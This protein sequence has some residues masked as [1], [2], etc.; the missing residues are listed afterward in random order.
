MPD[1]ADVSRLIDQTVRTLP[2][3]FY[4]G[5]TRQSDSQIVTVDIGDDRAAMDI[6]MYGVT[7][8]AVTGR[9]VPSGGPPTQ[10]VQIVLVQ[11]GDMPGAIGVSEIQPVQ[12]SADGRFRFAGVAPGTYSLLVLPTTQQR[13]G[14]NGYLPVTV[15][16][17]DVED[18]VVTLG[19]GLTLTGR[20]D[21]Q[22]ARAG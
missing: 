5:R 10:G 4:P 3:T 13:R 16:D 7:P 15:V 8:F 2:P 17:R 14:P 20:V 12:V 21:S 9:I 6:T 1:A 22:A 19:N 18:L 11:D